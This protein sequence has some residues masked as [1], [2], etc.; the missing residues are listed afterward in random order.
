VA[1]T[2]GPSDRDVQD[3]LNRY[4]GARFDGSIDLKYTATT[5]LCPTHGVRVA[6]TY[7][8]SYESGNGP[9][10]SRCC[11]AAEHVHLG[12]NYVHASRR[13]TAERRAL[14]EAKVVEHFGEPFNRYDHWHSQQFI[15]FDRQTA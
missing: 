8:H 11:A 2:D 6:E 7:G 14:L 5:W 1:W 15:E 3:L 4:A 10:D 13:I 12:A 9:V